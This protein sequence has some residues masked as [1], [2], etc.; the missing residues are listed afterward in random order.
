MALL[1][2]NNPV[3]FGWGISLGGTL[4]IIIGLYL[5]NINWGIENFSKT[6]SLPLYTVIPGILIILSIWSISKPKMIVYLP[7]KSLIFLTLAFSCWFIAEQ[8]WNLYEHVLVIDPY[9]SIA[10]FFYLA[11]PIF[12]FCALIFFLKLKKNKVTK[13]KIVLACFLSALILIPSIFFVF[14]ENTDSNL[15]E[16]I[17]GFSYPVVDSILLVPVIIAILLTVTDKENFFWIMILLGVICFIIA[18]SVFLFLVLNDEYVDGHPIDILWISGYTIWTFMMFYSIIQS[19]QHTKEDYSGNYKKF[20]KK[21]IENY[22]IL[23]ILIIINAVIVVLLLE[24]NNFSGSS[25][26]VILTYFSLILI[27]TVI[28][29]SSMV[30]ILNSKLN[31]SLQSKT[32]QL[33]QATQEMIKS[34][35]FKAIGELASR[36]SHD[37]RNPLSNIQ[38][39]IELMKNSPPNTKLENIL[40][41]EKLDLVSKNIERISHQVNDVLGY[42]KNRDIKKSKF[43][44]ASCL[45][46]SLEVVKIPRTITVKTS[47]LEKYI[48]ADQ[49]QFQIV[50]NNLLMNA[51]Q[52]IDNKN[53]EIFVGEIE[54]NNEIILEFSNSGPPIPEDILPHIFDSLVTTKQRGT[55]LGLVSCKTIIEN[56]G[57]TISAKNNPTTF[58]VTL[59]KT[60]IPEI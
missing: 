44:I 13:K 24:I 49:F 14:E 8:T 15:T 9:P 51:I 56:H 17:I 20:D 2:K 5:A 34:E 37:I 19:G 45:S 23:L 31:K 52:A 3:I 48:F 42:V 35:R 55:G 10:D 58:T 18:D 32:R 16:I 39:S 27:V 11:A 54:N 43:Q 4:A 38:M 29:F 22:G 41:Q 47:N 7:R 1:K 46:E 26:H 53:G 28:I 36:V 50:F 57:G 30:V 59:P 6:V 60:T 25:D 33:E 21:I 40:I 12:M